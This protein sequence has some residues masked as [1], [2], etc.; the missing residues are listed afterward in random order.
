MENNVEAGEQKKPQKETVREQ[1]RR[2]KLSISK[3]RKLRQGTHKAKGD[4]NET[5]S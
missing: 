4:L 2:M 1:A 3:V 5:R